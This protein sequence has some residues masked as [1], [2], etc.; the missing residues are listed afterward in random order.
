MERAVDRECHKMHAFVRFREVDGE[1]VARRYFAWF[2]PE[3]EILRRAVPFFAKR[4]ANMDWTIATPDGAARLDDGTLSFVDAPPLQDR[5]QRQ[6]RTSRCGAPITAASATSRAST[7]STMQREMPQRYWR[8]LPETAEIARLVRDGAELFAQRHSEQ[9]D[10]ALSHGAR[11]P[12]CTRQAAALR[13]TGLRRAGAASCGGTRRRP[14]WAKGRRRR[15]SCWWA[16]SRAMRRTCAA[17]RS[18]ARRD[19]CSTMRSRQRASTRGEL[20]ITNAVKHFKWE[21]RGKRR[22]HRRP[23]SVEISACNVWLQSEIRSRAAARDRRPR[24]HRVA[25]ADRLIGFDRVFARAALWLTRA[26][27]SWYARTTLPRSCEPIRRWPS[28]CVRASW[29]T[30]GM[31]SVRAGQKAPGRRR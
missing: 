24:R 27:H 6:M 14:W 8:N 2:E 28:G 23:D 26:A 16:S 29:R 7:P 5:P 20:F 30:S 31:A 22:L 13:V 1:A 19:A 17:S 12:E 10:P 9:D 11:G 4:F 15:G 25:R 21:P 3:H 18:W